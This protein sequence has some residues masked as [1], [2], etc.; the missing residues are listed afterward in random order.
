MCMQYTEIVIKSYLH[1]NHISLDQILCGSTRITT[2]AF[3]PTILYIGN[4][5]GQSV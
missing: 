2:S 5:I 1:D 3:R 4:Q